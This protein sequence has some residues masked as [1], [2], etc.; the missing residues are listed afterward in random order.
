MADQPDLFAAGVAEATSAVRLASAEPVQ[1]LQGRFATCG[2]EGLDEGDTLALI[3]DRCLTPGADAVGAA[4]ALLARFGGLGRILG[5]PEADLAKFLG[6]AAA[7]QLGLLHALLL[8]ALEH[9]LRA[10][11]VLTSTEAV[12]TYL[13]ARLGALPRE[14]FHVLFLDKK[15]QLIADERMGVGSVDHAPVYPREV[16][17][18]ALELSASSLVLAH[19]H[20]SGDPTP[21]RA[22][23]DMT[24]LLMEAARALQIA[25]HDHMVVAGDQ[26][27]S[28]RALGLM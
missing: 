15:N 4:D 8:R 16:M 2:V 26:V 24:K 28:L 18:R 23:I 7:R 17:R 6:V 14:V 20:P 3:L 5:A 25:V 9:P 12:R 22:D 27:A 13:R 21:S 11:A 19:N 10:R 1:D